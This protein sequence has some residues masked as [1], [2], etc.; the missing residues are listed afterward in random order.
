MAEIF[1][2]PAVVARSVEL[3]WSFARLTGKPLISGA[4]PDDP[5][6]AER[7][8]NIPQPLVSHGTESDPVFCYANRAAL[9]L[10]QMAWD[11]F[12]RLP[13]RHSAQE[14]PAIQTDRTRFLHQAATQGWVADYAG[15]RVSAL[16]QR[17]RIAETILWNVQDLSGTPLGQAAL[18]GRVE[19][20]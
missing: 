10:W 11:D 15:I 8:F 17:F 12:T 3:G 1:H 14:D 4:N 9:A 6:F 2:R 18:I 13:S 16:G 7:L 19:P 5:G 20:L